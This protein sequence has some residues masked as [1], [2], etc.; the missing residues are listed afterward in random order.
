MKTIASAALFSIVVLALCHRAFAE[1]SGER[2]IDV[3]A[4]K[5]SFSVTHVFVAR[6]G[7]TMPI[8]SG[9]VTL[10]AGSLVP[11]G[12][13]AVIDARDVNTGDRDQSA[14][15]RSPDYFDVARF[16]EI[17]FRSTKIEPEGPAS[18]GMDGLLTIHG[19]AQPEH[20]DVTISGDASHPVYR[21][22]GHVDRH[23]FGMR[24]AR[25]DPTIG[26]VVDVMLDIVL[27]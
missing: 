3:R 24:G 16:P 19:T 9:S 2:A 23:A 25:L 5:A 8:S 11:V 17:T 1:T 4:S 22:V 15:I 20:L 21:A 14:C 7:G 27:K 26:G 10:A 13:T 12:A 18:F 6:V